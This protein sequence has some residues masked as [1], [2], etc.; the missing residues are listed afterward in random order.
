VV[1]VAALTRL[2]ASH[3]ITRLR[4]PLFLLLFC[5][6][7]AACG[8]QEAASDG[9][10]LEIILTGTQGGP[11]L[12][13]G[14][15]GP[16]TLV[17][18]GS[19]AN[20][21]GDLSLQFDAGRGTIESISRLDISPL[22]VD[23]VFLTHMHSDH[24]EGLSGLLLHRWHFLGEPIDVVC[25]SDVVAKTPPERT[26]SCRGFVEHTADA[27]V[28]SGEILQRHAENEKRDP[29]G[30]VSLVRLQT[31]DVPIEDGTVVWRFGDV[32]VSAISTTHIAGSLAF[33]VDSPAGSVVI[34]G[35]ASNSKPSPPRA[36]STSESVEALAVGADVLVHSVMHPV[37]APGKGSGFKPLTY[38]RQSNATDLG[39]MAERAGIRHLVLTH[40]IP[41]LDAV[42]HGPWTVP[43][44][45]LGADD[46]ETAVRDLTTIRLP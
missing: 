22:D 34:G 27:H 44:G 38:H 13:N 33:R 4:K 41:A 18:Y 12:V 11:T 14:L 42:A 16:G 36:S 21:C 20:G 10:C 35:D 40:M 15:A 23:A 17:R 43:G 28:Q 8:G 46:F 26:I 7:P 2:R 5:V 45:P 30:P 19:E 39:S 1:F 25:A 6:L 37:F 24:T 9:H 31:V 32:S 3:L 29:A